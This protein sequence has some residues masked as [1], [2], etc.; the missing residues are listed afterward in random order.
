MVLLPLLIVTVLVG[1][2]LAG[3]GFGR[4]GAVG[5]RAAGRETWFRCGAALAAAAA[6]ALYAWGLLGVGLALVVTDESGTDAFPPRP[7][8][9]EGDPGAASDVV[10][11][12]VTYLP[13]R[14]SCVRQ[15]GDAY[16]IDTGGGAAGPAAVVL[17]AASGAFAC[18][19]L[20][21]PRHN[22]RGRA[23]KQV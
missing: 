7:C 13:P 22:A 8:R 23:V 1:F 19:A 6:A 10:G 12:R 2:G 11:H 18:L 15:D 16:A 17:L 4:L 9:V 14:Y 5:V 3:Y 20:A 21:E